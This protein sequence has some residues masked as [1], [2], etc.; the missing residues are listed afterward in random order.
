MSQLKV[1]VDNVLVIVVHFIFVDL[2][3]LLS[4]LMMFSLHPTVKTKSKGTLITVFTVLPSPTT[5]SLLLLIPFTTLVEFKG[6]GRSFVI[7]R[8]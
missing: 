7:A 4:A 3:E 1:V 6:Q 5:L 8:V 2:S